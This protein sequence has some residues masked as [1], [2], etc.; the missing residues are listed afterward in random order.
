MVFLQPA[1]YCL[2]FPAGF[3]RLSRIGQPDYRSL[4][5]W[6]VTPSALVFGGGLLPTALGY[7]GE[8]YSIGAGITLAGVLIIMGFPLAFFLKLIDKMEDGC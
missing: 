7:M 6:W 4:A 2:L 3:V 5:T 1:P 8:A